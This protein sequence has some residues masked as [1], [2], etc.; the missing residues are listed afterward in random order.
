MNV[1]QAGTRV[2]LTVEGLSVSYRGVRAVHDVSFEVPA[3]SC[4]AIV[5]A[6]GAG[7]TSIL[8][9]VS[10]LVRA[11]RGCRIRL[12]DVDLVPRR[13]PASRAKEGLGHVLEGRHVFTAMTV[14]ENLALAH[15]HRAG[16]QGADWGLPLAMQLFP[17]LE[18]MMA[19]KAGG[20]SGGQQQYL[21]I[22]R[23]LAAQPAVL[24][25]DEPTNGLAPQLV[26]RV[27]DVL[28]A[29]RDRGIAVLLVEQ[30]VDVALATAEQVQVLSHGRIVASPRTG[31]AEIEELIQSAYLA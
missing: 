20:L 17:E 25:L 26:D 30:R 14:H 5:G 19:R 8:N 13:D 16:R 4:V 11:R 10:G 18:P 21:A 12:G 6:N 24:M 28:E 22:A 7:K 15:R 27:V 29:V 2:G 1:G 23:A 31:D 3:G 9:A